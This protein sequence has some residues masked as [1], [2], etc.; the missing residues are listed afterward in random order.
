MIQRGS[1]QSETNFADDLR[2]GMY[3]EWYE[4]IKV[5]QKEEGLWVQD[6][7]HEIWTYWNEFQ[8]K[9]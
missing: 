1:K 9:L 6:K 7:K 3:F 8:E 5:R 2:E 4:S